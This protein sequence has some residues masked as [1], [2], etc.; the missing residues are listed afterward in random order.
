MVG[1][2]C[3][4]PKYCAWK[5]GLRTALQRA[6]AFARTR[7]FGLQRLSIGHQLSSAS[8]ADNQGGAAAPAL[9]LNGGAELRSAQILRLKMGRTNDQSTRESFCQDQTIRPP[10][11]FHRS[12]IVV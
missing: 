6:R 1:Q 7:L 5:L 10:K 12:S 4:L 3:A 11:T 2:S 8:H 9:P